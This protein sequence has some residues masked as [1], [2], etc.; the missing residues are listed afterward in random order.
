[1]AEADLLPL[2][3]VGDLLR[4]A[5]YLGVL[6]DA[7]RDSGWRSGTSL[8]KIHL[9]F[10]ALFYFEQFNST[11]TKMIP[12]RVLLARSVWKGMLQFCLICFTF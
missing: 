6:G 11:T 8:Q 4:K 3:V 10:L 2:F 5:Q 9:R 1:V 12:T 7:K